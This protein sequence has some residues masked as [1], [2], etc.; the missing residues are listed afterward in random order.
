MREQAI[1]DRSKAEIAIREGDKLRLSFMPS[2]YGLRWNSIE[3][4]DLVMN[5]SKI[6]LDGAARRIDEAARNFLDDSSRAGLGAP[7][8]V[9]DNANP[10]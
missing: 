4:I 5:T 10:S 8:F 3:H 2:V 9:L 7:D 6:G 1:G